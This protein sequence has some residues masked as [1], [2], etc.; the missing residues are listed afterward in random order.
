[1]SLSLSGTSPHASAGRNRADSNATTATEIAEYEPISLVELT[2]KK[3]PGATFAA[4]K[5]VGA[6]EE[7]KNILNNPHISE[8][9][10]EITARII[11]AIK[12]GLSGLETLLE[13]NPDDSNIFRGGAR[14]THHRRSKTHRRRKT[15]HHNKKR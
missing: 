14:R 1:M 3:M 4:Q 5:L 10:H 13:N 6:I 2:E 15:A 9:R 7:F 12:S 8:R 11:P